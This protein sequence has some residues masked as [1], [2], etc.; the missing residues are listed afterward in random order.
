MSITVTELL[1]KLKKEKQKQN[2]DSDKIDENF[3]A[4]TEEDEELEIE[5]TMTEIK[6]Q[7][8]NDFSVIYDMIDNITKQIEEI[9]KDVNQ[10]KIQSK[11]KYYKETTEFKEQNKA[12]NDF[13]NIPQTERI[14]KPVIKKEEINLKNMKILEKTS[15]KPKKRTNSNTRKR[16]I[17]KRKHYK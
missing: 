13:F 6:S 2:K 9:R 4:Q 12:Y 14:Y 1:N 17:S 3:E 11:V 10:L 5:D 16:S 15:E 8:D 7:E